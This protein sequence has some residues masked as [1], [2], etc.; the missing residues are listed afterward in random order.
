M[1][2]LET[3]FS[4][5]G[6]Y[7]ELLTFFFLFDFVSTMRMQPILIAF[8]KLIFLQ[9][10]RLE[11][12]ETEINHIYMLNASNLKHENIIEDTYRILKINS[13]CAELSF[14]VIRFY[15]AINSHCQNLHGMGG[16]SKKNSKM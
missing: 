2:I 5:L 12:Y 13:R 11:G 8:T 16:T 14:Q 10:H 15:L 3:I 6:G 1:N 9:I 4:I 7:E